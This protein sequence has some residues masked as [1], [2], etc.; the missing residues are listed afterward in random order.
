MYKMEF[1]FSML[2]VITDYPYILLSSK[3]P[4]TCS[5]RVNY[6]ELIAV[7]I[8]VPC[9]NNFTRTNKFSNAHILTNK[10]NKPTLM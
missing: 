8:P 4:T 9:H 5:C 3:Y 7:R 1:I 10:K 2:T 6:G